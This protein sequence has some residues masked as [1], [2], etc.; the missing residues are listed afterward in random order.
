VDQGRLGGVARGGARILVAGGALVIAAGAFL[1]WAYL[2]VG[3]GRLPLP[4]V[5]G[6]GG[7]TLLLGLVLLFRARVH[8]A[9]GLLM[10]VA[11]GI[12]A[13]LFGDEVSRTL[14]G[15]LIGLQLWLAPLN[16]LL[17]QFHISG[18]EVVDLGLARDAYLGPGLAVTAWGAWLAA[19]GHGA[20]LLLP[21]EGPPA[22]QDRLAP[23]RCGA[24]GTTVPRARAAHFCP[25]CGASLGGP[26]LCA[27]CLTP[28]APAD[29]YCV[30]CGAALST[31]L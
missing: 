21:G 26:P 6:P 4:G 22:L 28:A 24:C 5:L 15:A 9:A 13:P 16:R 23:R 7:L 30:S 2:P 18:I 8:P 27:R 31:G 3:R 11:V 1:P 12:G 14:R 17:E 10:G 29:R 20:R 19:I 25:G